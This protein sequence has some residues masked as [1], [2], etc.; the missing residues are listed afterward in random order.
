MPYTIPTLRT[1]RLIIRPFVREDL[2]RVYR[3]Y[4]VELAD[5]SMGTT[6]AQTLEGRKAWLEWTIQGYSQLAHLYQPPYG[7]RAIV[8]AQTGE[9][10]GAVA[11]SPVLISTTGSP[12]CAPP[13]PRP[14]E[15]PRPRW[16]CSTA[17]LRHTS[18]TATPPRRPAP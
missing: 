14:P 8:L 6:G 5:A 16:A 12:G 4:D 11:S 3:L 7:D 13:R 10:I 2:E 17:S 18:V 1:D 9:L 15:E